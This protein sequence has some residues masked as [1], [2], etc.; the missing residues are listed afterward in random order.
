MFSFRG[1]QH[2]TAKQVQRLLD[3][4]KLREK[5]VYNGK[6]LVEKKY[7]WDIIADDMKGV[8]DELMS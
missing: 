4:D 5:I 1:E 2:F 6:K 7:D 8:F 3:D